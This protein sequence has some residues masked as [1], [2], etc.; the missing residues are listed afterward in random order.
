MLKPS[1]GKSKMLNSVEEICQ[2]FQI[3]EHRL[4]WWRS[5]PGFPVKI[6]CG[7]LTGHKDDIENFMKVYILKPGT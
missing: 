5:Q 3:G 2:A 6:I 1:E 7:R 4:E